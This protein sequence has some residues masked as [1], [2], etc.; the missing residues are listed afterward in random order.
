MGGPGGQGSLKDL[1]GHAAERGDAGAGFG[2]EVDLAVRAVAL[3]QASS[4]LE[5]GG[6]EVSEAEPVAVG[7]PVQ[8]RQVR[9]APQRRE[10]YRPRTCRR[11]TR[12]L[13]LWWRKVVHEGAEVVPG[14]LGCAGI[15]AV[16]K[17]GIGTDG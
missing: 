17:R 5:E 14:G 8:V 12:R 1:L 3:E 6:D 11:R 7:Q 16:A 2:V 4:D 15:R 9:L 13:Q 10:P